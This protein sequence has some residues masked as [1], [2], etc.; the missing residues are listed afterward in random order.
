MSVAEWA[1]N[2]LYAE[3]LKTEPANRGDVEAKLYAA[4][5]RHAQAVL[6]TKLNEAP[7]DLVASVGDAVITQLTKFRRKSKFSTWVQGIAQ[8]KAKQYIRGKVRARKI[9]DEYTVVVESEEEDALDR[10]VGEIT[11]SVSPDAEGEIAVTKFRENLSAEDAAL[12][13]H[14]EEGLKGKEIA[15]K[16]GT[17]VEAV[18]SR[19]ARLKPRVKKIRP[20]RRK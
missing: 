16:M 8:R 20:T 9:F 6:W 3:W 11:P 7:D 1:E 10:R 14:K 12:L 5:K 15:Q 19:W 13:Q 18:D 2:K 4:V 17:T